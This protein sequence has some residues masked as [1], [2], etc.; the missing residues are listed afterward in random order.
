MGALRITRWL[1]KV[2]RSTCHPIRRSPARLPEV[3]LQSFRKRGWCRRHRGDHVVKKALERRSESDQAL[4]LVGHGRL[5]DH[6]TSQRAAITGL[7][8]GAGHY[9]SGRSVARGGITI[10]MRLPALVAKRAGDPAAL[11]DASLVRSGG[12]S[13]VASTHGLRQRFASCLCKWSSRKATSSG[14]PTV[15]RRASRS[16]GVSK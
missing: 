5:S 6:K 12:C 11:T 8:S 13:N 16:S 2:W 4:L 3:L 7:C 14:V 10:V 9:R 1:A 15:I